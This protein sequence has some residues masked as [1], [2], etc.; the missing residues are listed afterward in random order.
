MEGRTGFQ[1]Q[2]KKKKYFNHQT[3]SRLSKQLVKKGGERGRDRGLLVSVGFTGGDDVRHSSA[4]LE[5]GKHMKITMAVKMELSVKWHILG[6][7]GKR[8]GGKGGGW[9]GSQARENIGGRFTPRPLENGRR[10][11]M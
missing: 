9:G 1:G 3:D 11:K 4:M 8:R 6:R 2:E 10:N 7:R 5:L